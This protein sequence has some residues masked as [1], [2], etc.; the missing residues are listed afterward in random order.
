MYALTIR[1]SRD[2]RKRYT[3]HILIEN[4]NEGKRERENM[5]KNEERERHIEKED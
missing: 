4:E 2:S 5:R 3:L 1:M